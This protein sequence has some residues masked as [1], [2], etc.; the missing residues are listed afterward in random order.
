MATS[1]I[2]I[3]TDLK[4]LCNNCIIWNHYYSSSCIVLH[5]Q[6]C[7]S[8]FTEMLLVQWKT[9]PAS[10]ENTDALHHRAKLHL[11]T[12]SMPGA[13]S[14][15]ILWNI[16][17]NHNTF[18]DS[19]TGTFSRGV[20][21]S[22]CREIL[23]IEL[24]HKL[25]YTG[26][27]EVF[28]AWKTSRPKLTSPLHPSHYSVGWWSVWAPRLQ[29]FLV[30]S[31]PWS[32][33]SSA[34]N[35]HTTP[36]AYDYCAL[37]QC[38]TMMECIKDN[39]DFSHLFSSP[40]C[41]ESRNFRQF[42]QNFDNIPAIWELCRNRRRY[43]RILFRH[44]RQILILPELSK[45]C[46]NCRDCRKF[47][48]SGYVWVGQAWFHSYYH[49]YCSWQKINNEANVSHIN[50]GVFIIYLTPGAGEFE[51]GRVC[52]VNNDQPSYGVC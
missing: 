51:G 21:L 20:H 46:R 19:G 36:I 31:V 27:K 43:R 22:G 32:H 5:K 7:D 8:H 30:Y 13:Q 48:D 24:D 28:L 23:G 14:T 4:S 41:Y 9:S 25:V 33:W 6:P 1:W 16:P 39:T 40:A 26:G 44:F 12:W 15:Y 2:Q 47:R 45:H 37:D 11:Q 29:Q 3:V 38:V 18:P 50:K 42:R 49:I 34:C 35:L 17:T 52:V 10:I